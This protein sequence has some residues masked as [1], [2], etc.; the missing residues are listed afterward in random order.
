MGIYW[1]D[2]ATGKKMIHFA[3]RFHDPD[4]NVAGIVFAGLDLDW[5]LG[6]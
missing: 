3:E 4:G 6:A 1:K 5:L 2:P